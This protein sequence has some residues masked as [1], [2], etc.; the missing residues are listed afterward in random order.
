[1]AVELGGAVRAARVEGRLLRLWHHLYLAEHLRGGRLV[2]SYFRVYGT[3][4]LEQARDAKGIGIARI[5]RLLER[6]RNETLRRQIID[7][8]GLCLLQNSLNVTVFKELEGDRLDGV[9]Y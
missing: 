3:D 8:V 1:M 6:G 4:G 9:F 7:L 5:Q 2:E